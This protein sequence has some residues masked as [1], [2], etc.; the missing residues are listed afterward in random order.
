MFRRP[1]LL[2]GWCVS[3][4]RDTVPVVRLLVVD[5]NPDVG[6]ALAMLL[7]TLGHEVVTVRDGRGALAAARQRL[8]HVAVVDVGL[9]DMSGYDVARAVRSLPGGSDVVLLALTG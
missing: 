9:P 2:M 6:D 3:I 4:R 5:D 1:H 7:E 8:P